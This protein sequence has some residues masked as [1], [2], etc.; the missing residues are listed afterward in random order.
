MTDSKTKDRR[1]PLESDLPKELASPARR[2][3][4]QAGFMRLDQ[5]AGHR[6]DEISRLH[7]MGPKALDQLRRALSAKGLSF[8]SEGGKDED[9]RQ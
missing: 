1:E 5:L 3:L 9:D 8:A 7:G 6:E 4:A 2:A